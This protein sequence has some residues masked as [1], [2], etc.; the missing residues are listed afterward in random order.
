MRRA[1]WLVSLSLAASPA[2]ALAED[3]PKAPHAEGE[4]GG[5]EPGQPKK[6]EPGKKAKKAPPKGTLSWIGFEAKDGS[7]DVFLQSPAPFEVLQRV[8]N[9]TLIVTLSHISR[10][11]Q[12]TWRPIDTRFFATPVARITAKKKG[13][14]VEV[15]IAFKSAKEAAQGAVRTETGADGMYYVHLG[16]SGGAAA[17]PDSA[18]AADKNSPE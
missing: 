4:Y 10:L 18:P 11:G 8:E 17:E 14:S 9:G 12:N 7:S 13:S 16:F 3:M 15:R 6:P 2:L 1:I 5:V